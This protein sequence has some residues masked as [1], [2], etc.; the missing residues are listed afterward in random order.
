MRFIYLI[1]SKHN[2]YAGSH[3]VINRFFGL[4][5]HIIIGSY[6]NNSNIRYFRTTGTH[7]CKCFVTRSIKESDTASVFQLHVVCT[8]MLGNT[9][10]LTCNYICLTNIVQQ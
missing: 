5:H 3:S 10:G 1:N 6:N 8:D 4:R 9:T 7:R 2:R